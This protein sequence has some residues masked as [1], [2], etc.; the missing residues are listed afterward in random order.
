[1][2]DPVKEPAP[3]TAAPS[4]EPAATTPPAAPAPTPAADPAAPAAPAAAAKEPAASMVSEPAKAEPAATAAPA[5]AEPKKEEPKPDTK[6]DP[7]E[8]AKPA[9]PE[10]YELKLPDGSKL[11]ADAVAKVE[12]LAKEKG[13]TNER[14]QEALEQRHAAVSEFE[15]VQASSLKNLNE[16]TWK[17]QLQADP[18][19]GGQKFEQSGHLAYKAAERFGGKEFADQLKAMNLN[20]QPM[21][22]KYLV[23]VGR[24]MESDNFVPNNPKAPGSEPPEKRMYPD[25]YKDKGAK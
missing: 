18:D 16:V 19:V 3:A 9:V 12:A 2:S 13:W 11:G 1:M 7:T 17:E 24:A 23:K 14:A 4:A 6:A 20:H 22:F 10:K 5:A 8:A 25:M 21:L 15:Q